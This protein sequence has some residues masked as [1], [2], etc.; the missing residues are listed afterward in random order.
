MAAHLL[1]LDEYPLDQ[2]QSKR[3]L[4]L[5]AD[6][7]EQLATRRFFDIENFLTPS[8]ATRLVQEVQNRLPQA[9][10]SVSHTNPHPEGAAERIPDD[11]RCAGQSCIIYR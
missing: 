1:N 11:Q 4:A 10:H 8:G 3:Y 5:V 9:F 2:P 6:Y 7:R